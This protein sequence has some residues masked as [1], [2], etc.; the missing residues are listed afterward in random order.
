MQLIPQNAIISTA[1]A[2][3][4]EIR[5]RVESVFQC[6]VFNR[7]G[8]REAGDIACERPDMEG[9]WVAP[10]GNFI[11]IVDENG[12][13]LPDGEE[14]ELLV[15]S[16]S[17]YAMPLIR[18]QIGD[19]GV[20]AKQE[21]NDQSGIQIIEKITGRTIDRFINRNGR[22]IDA[23]YFMPL[24][25]HRDWINKYQVIQKSTSQIEIRMVLGDLVP[26]QQELDE[27]VQVGKKIMHDEKC[28]IEI[29]FVTNIENDRSGKYRFIKS[30][31]H[32]KQDLNAGNPG[33]S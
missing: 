3:H 20:L 12:N 4:P 15:T 16:L 24:F 6:R 8:T 27:I 30:E 21:E 29:K 23:G 26:G 18:Y 22:S 33:S 19:R 13:R 5:K 14:G 28:E 17:N 32:A 10:W 25:Y 1:G 7:Y 9:L 2:L 11:E 31:I